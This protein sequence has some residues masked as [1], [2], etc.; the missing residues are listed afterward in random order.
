MCHVACGAFLPHVCQVG[1]EFV[2]NWNPE[3][4]LNLFKK[5]QITQNNNW[6][7][8]SNPPS[9]KCKRYWLLNLWITATK[10]DEHLYIN[11]HNSNNSTFCSF[12]H[13][14]LPAGVLNCWDRFTKRIQSAGNLGLPEKEVNSKVSLEDDIWFGCL[15]FVLLR[16]RKVYFLEVLCVKRVFEYII[17]SLLKM[18]NYFFIVKVILFQLYYII[19]SGWVCLFTIFCII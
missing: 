3:I 2:T 10:K 7:F 5:S 8:I 14:V 9:Y 6:S 18:V 12:R 15:F 11:E 13:Q 17:L 1:K 16:K 4:Y 19:G